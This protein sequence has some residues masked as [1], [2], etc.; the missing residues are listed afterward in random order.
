MD[1][2]AE[3]V[4]QLQTYEKNKTGSNWKEI[5]KIL[6]SYQIIESY[7]E[8]T[9]VIKQ[10]CSEIFNEEFLKILSDHLVKIENIGKNLIETITLIL[11]KFDPKSRERRIVESCLREHFEDLEITEVDHKKNKFDRFELTEKFI[12]KRPELKSNL[13]KGSYES[14]EDY[15][16]V[17][18][19]LIIED[20]VRPLRQ[21]LTDIK[22]RCVFNL[23]LSL[24]FYLFIFILFFQILSIFFS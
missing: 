24:F 14:L 23:I 9:E 12:M 20:F 8:E 16:R 3:A 19:N 10:L 6:N 11:S 7:T 15:L 5:V 13:C 17:Q 4:L 2:F 1:D 21:G 22:S 18:R